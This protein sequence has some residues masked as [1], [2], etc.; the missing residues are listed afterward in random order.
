MSGPEPESLKSW[1]EARGLSWNS[2]ATLPP[3]TERLRRG[4]G[5]GEHR[6]SYRDVSDR[7]MTTITGSNSKKPERQTVGV[8]RGQLPGGL[9]GLVGHHMHL[10]DQGSGQEDRYLAITDTVVFAELPLR[11]RPV[12]HLVGRIAPDGD[13]KGGIWIGKEKSAEEMNSPLDGVVPAPQ[14][15]EESGGMEWTSFPAEPPE[16]IRRIGSAATRF[17]DGLPMNQIEV[18]Y[19]C[20]KL[21]VWVKGRVLTDQMP[22]DQLCRFASAVADGLAE[23]TD[24]SPGLELNQPLPQQEPDARDQWVSDGANLVEW[25]TAPVS[26]VAA[27]ERYKK[28]I[29]PHAKR[30]GWKVYGIVGVSLFV[31]SV[32]IAVV[33]L[34]T[35]FVLDEF[36]PAIGIMV[37][38]V[39]IAFGTI[40]AN[41]IGLEAGQ[42]AMDDRL[43]S[44]ATPWG[45]E[46]FAR[47]YAEHAGLARENHDELRR[48]I[49]VPFSGRPQIAWQGDFAPGLPGH[50]ST[51]IDAT[52]TPEPPRFYLLAVTAATGAKSPAGYLTQEDGGLRLTWQEVT[53]VQR[54]THRLD[55]LREA[56]T[57]A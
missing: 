32:L 41:R 7:G 33:S 19:E 27:Q 47:G 13:V 17:L 25:E 12:F 37:A 10:I 4:V 51:W 23:V 11:A 39:S 31:V 3:V 21:A 28:D 49:E 36:P 48:R 30:T 26:I 2:E 29:Q 46:A 43:A 34:A 20:G 50:I 54:A 52:N 18:E 5:V 24:A 1:A 14:G 38:V 22:L 53:S 40:A 9:E 8:S 56:A 44:S 45:I 42:G 35:S 55:Q 15:V 57:A 16:R 6:A